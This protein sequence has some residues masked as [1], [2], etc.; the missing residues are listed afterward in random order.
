MSKLKIIANYLPQYHITEENNRWWGE[1]FTDWIS[2]KNAN[3][4]FKGHKQPNIPLNNNYYK[5][6]DINAIRWQ[7]QLAKKYGVYGFGIYHYWFSTEQNLLKKPA[8]ILL[9]NRDIDVNFLFLWDNGSWKRTWSKIKMAN[10]WAP[11]YDNKN[12]V[13]N[14]KDDGI[15]AK[16]IYGDENDWYIHFMYLLPFFKD[17]RYIKIDNKPLF[18]FYQ[19]YNKFEIIQK[20]ICFW[21]KLAK[22]NGFNGIIC[23]NRDTY[24]YKNKRMEYQFKYAPLSIE[25]FY[26]K[27]R[28]KIY[29]VLCKTE[30]RPKI[31][32]YDKRWREIIYNAKKASDKI[33]LSG[34]VNYDDTPRRGRQGTL[35]KGATPEKFGQYI[36]QLAKIAR[37]KNQE[38]IFITA[39]NEWAEGAYLEPDTINEYAYL[40]QLKMAIDKVNK[41]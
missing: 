10:D 11:Q 28:Y 36:Y 4:L 5:L 14:K 23:M 37:S 31:Y 34:F 32:D 26:Q 27:I 19:P 3:S 1:G 35:F 38:F 13:L 33:F 39:W 29:D 20:M 18:G 9:E 17:N 7:A 15:L 24:G 12:E 41:D 2:T 40:E 21:D 30:K 6:D 16:L 8:E 22:K 25:S